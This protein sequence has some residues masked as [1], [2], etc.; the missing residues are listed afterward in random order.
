MATGTL[1]TALPEPQPLD[2]STLPAPQPIGSSTSDMTT[3]PAP[4]AL[5]SSLPAPT[6]LAPSASSLQ[7]PRIPNPSGP[8]TIEA[9]KP[10]VWERISNAF[11]EGIPALNPEF[12]AAAHTD[13]GTLVGGV[14][15]KMQL[16]APEAAMSETEQ[17]RHPI[18]TGAGQIVGGITSPESAALI[19]GTAGLGELPGAAR[20][21]VPRLLSAGFGLQ[22][23]TSAY[24]TSKAARDAF[25]R[26]DT[27][28][29]ERLLTAAILS[30]GM[31]LAAGTHA[32]TGKSVFGTAPEET[33][34]QMLDGCSGDAQMDAADRAAGRAVPG[35]EVPF[36]PTSAVG[37][38]LKEPAPAVRL[39]D[40]AAARK[41]LN[42]N[43]R[44]HRRESP[45][46]FAFSTEPL[47]S[48]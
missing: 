32:A 15:P 23:I 34:P 48:P 1:S 3:L 18:L 29:G 7:P 40:T 14:T 46:R 39:V 45:F 2:V 35:I 33:K 26:G 20:L 25:E 38:V 44:S 22:A 11:A 30:G 19:A 8:T 31:A 28:E 21:V 10:S 17:R 42:R 4:V 9:Y 27:S 47:P 16:I 43:R 36:A 41:K 12:A 6:P 13:S 5:S 37:S 24:Q